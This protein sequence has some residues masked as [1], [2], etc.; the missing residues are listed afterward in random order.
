MC[1]FMLN[2]KIISEIRRKVK[3]T[4]ANGPGST[5]SAFS[6]IGVGA[7]VTVLNLVKI[8]NI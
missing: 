6:S 1:R 7:G 5:V 2:N 3:T 8:E 4:A